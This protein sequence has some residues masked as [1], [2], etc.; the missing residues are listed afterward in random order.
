MKR[1]RRHTHHHRVPVASTKLTVH[2]DTHAYE[3]WIERISPCPHLQLLRVKLQQ[4]LCLGRISLSPKGWGFI[5]Q[6]ILFGYKIIGNKLIIQ[7][8]LGRVSLVPAL[9]NYKAVRRFISTQH[10]RLD[11]TISPHILKQQHLPL[12]PKER[13]LFSGNRNRYVLEEY[14]FTL[15]NGRQSTLFLLETT[16][17]YDETSIQ[18]IDPTQPHRPKIYRSVLYLLFEQG[19]HEFVL[20]HVLHHKQDKF[21]AALNK[22][23]DEGELKH[24]V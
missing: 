23:M 7:T 21:M 8:F 19:Y 18:L 4:L 1:Q 24:I 11:L 17:E 16:K 22:R 13:I 12:I 20:E 9:G 15:P 2:I 5:D 3:R 6:D 10:D 14:A